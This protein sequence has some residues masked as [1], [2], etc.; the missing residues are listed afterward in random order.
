[1]GT[2]GDWSQIIAIAVFVGLFGWA[3]DM[4]WKPYP[5]KLRRLLAG[6]FLVSTAFGI[7]ETF[8]SRAFR[9]PLALITVPAAVGGVILWYLARPRGGQQTTAETSADNHK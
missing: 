6:W 5:D 9:V 3:R 7:W 4:G 1:M 2:I 8:R